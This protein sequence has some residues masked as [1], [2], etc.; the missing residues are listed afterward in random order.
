MQA[1]CISLSSHTVEMQSLLCFNMLSP[2]A[3]LHHSWQEPCGLNVLWQYA[4]RRDVN[5]YCY[6]W[7]RLLREGAH[8]TPRTTGG[9]QK[10]I[11]G[12]RRLHVGGLL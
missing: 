10:L 8:V 2:E 9:I 6:V 3:T 1:H 5:L 12:K 7:E 11:G 4:W